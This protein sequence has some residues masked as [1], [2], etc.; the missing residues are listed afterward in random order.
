MRVGLD[1]TVPMR[2]RLAKISRFGLVD[3]ARASFYYSINR[4][5]N[6]L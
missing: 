2:A 4:L 1:S 6:G 5:N 3:I